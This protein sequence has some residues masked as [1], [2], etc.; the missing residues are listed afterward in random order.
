MPGEMRPINSYAEMAMRQVPGLGGLHRMTD[1]LLAERVPE[2][3]RVLVLGAG[4]GMELSNLAG[5][6][7]GWQF[8][9]V[10]PSESML[11]AARAATADCRERVVLHCGTIGIAPEGPFDGATS[12]LTFHFIPLEERLETLRQLHRRLKPGAPLVLAHMS[13]A[14]DAASRDIWMRRHAAFAVSNGV[15]KAQAESGRQ[16]MLERLHLLSPDRE[17]A[18]LAEVGF[19]GASL[20]FAGFDFR[21]WVAYAG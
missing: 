11:D 15:D 20:F 5:A 9:G 14:Q 4:G 18:M 1:L 12:I 6:H 17:E 19:R 2:R 10:D 7:A 21:G 13:F 3:G 16:A 8:D